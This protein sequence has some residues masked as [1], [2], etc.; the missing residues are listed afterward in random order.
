[1]E[2]FD[3]HIHSTASDGLWNPKQIIDYAIE[4]GLS[5]IAI[6]D[7]DTVANLAEAAEYAKKR[8][9]PFI[10]GIEI[11]SE[12]GGK[13]VH[14]LGYWVNY[15][16]AGLIANLEK[17]QAFRRERC[18]KIVNILA[19]L[20]MPLNAE[21][22]LAE[23]GSSIGRPHIAKAMIE[24]GFVATIGDAFQKWLGKGLPAYV[25][26]KKYSPAV[27]IKIIR[28]AGGAP[29]I[30]HPGKGLLYGILRC[31]VR[32]GLAGIEVFH[33]D[34]SAKMEKQCAE[35]ALFYGLAATGGSDYH[36]NPKRPIGFRT[37]SLAQLELLARLR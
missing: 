1:M 30:A 31:L 11:S 8:D 12:T 15:N 22:I 35:L 7:H 23:G 10:P 20:N 34:H 9:F 32:R 14:I 29:V 3:L 37:T 27:A 5:G 26:R 13:D 19:Q 17:F 28:K 33:P 18:L 4:K 24:A 6:T 21:K 25:P 16:D 2:G 36:G